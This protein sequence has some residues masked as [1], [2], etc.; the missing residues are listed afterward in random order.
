MPARHVIL[1]TAGHIDHGKTSL[2]KALTGVDTDRLPEEKARGMTIDLGFAHLDESATIIDVPGHE[3]FVKNMVAGVSTI[4]LVLFVIAA[5]DGV[6]PQTR[7]HLDIC[8]LLQ[9]PRGLIVLTKIDL[10]EA[11]WLALVQEDIRRLVQ[12]T[13]LARAPILPVSTVTGAGMAELK[14]HLRQLIAELPPRQDRGVFWMPVDR[15]F[16]MK[17]FGTVVTGSV[18]S[19]QTTL[20]EELELLPERLRVRVRGLQCHGHNTP[21]VQTGDRAAVNLQGVAIEQVM[22]G[23]VLAAPGY[24][25]PTRRSNCRVR[26]LAQAPAPLKRRTRVRVHLGTAEVMARVLPLTANELQPGES[27]LAQLRFEKPVAVRPRDPFVL[28]QYSPP[29][30]IGGGLVLEVEATRLRRRDPELLARLD[31]LEQH[32][33]T[34]QLVMQFLLP[35]RHAV[36]LTQLAAET[37]TSQESVQAAVE[38]LIQQR[39]VVAINKRT[40]I[41]R[42]RLDGLWHQLAALL[43]E[44]HEQHPTKPGLRKAE[45]SSRLPAL[46]DTALLNL[47]VR[48]ARAEN[49]LKEID[50]RLALADHQI[51]LSPAQQ[52]LRQQLLAALH[53]ARYAPPAPL[54]LAATCKATEAQVLEV[55]QVMSLMQ[56]VV[57]LGEGIWLHRDHLQEAHKRVIDYL[58]RHGE[59]TVGQ[60]KQLVDNTSRKFA[61]PLLQYFDATGVTQRQGEVRVLG[62][63]GAE[64]QI[65]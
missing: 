64:S 60:F 12:G 26:L 16:V 5:D 49:K 65:A 24:F 23:Q 43:A 44:Y 46:A 56:E 2:V 9:I 28:R 52:A 33:P 53:A 19:G 32:S 20:G 38:Q 50:A 25:G 51:H 22:R 18:L 57:R 3:K 30:T 54:E 11:N 55:L 37:N 27:G 47:L 45:V 6:M 61:I 4:D 14:Q 10:V 42:Q 13:F 58:R 62:I 41:H 29:R 63:E 7:E 1:G 48:T 15:A 21:L 39:A 35:G 34:E 8:E 40:F 31:A 17:G 36:T 59:M